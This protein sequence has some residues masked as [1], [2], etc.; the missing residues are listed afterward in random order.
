MYN[1]KVKTEIEIAA[2]LFLEKNPFI[3]KARSGKL[4]KAQITRYLKTILYSIEF[5]PIHLKAASLRANELGLVE[6]AKFMDEK[7]LEEFGHDRWVRA[8]LRKLGANANSNTDIELTQGII[9][10]IKFVETLVYG[11]PLYYI[12]YITFL[13]Y[14]TVLVAPE[15]LDCI[16]NKCGISRTALTVITN[17]GE[18][19]KNHVEDDFKALEIFVDGPEKSSQFIQ[20]IHKTAQILDQHFSECA[21]AA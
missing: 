3:I 2:K 16:V 20:I 4:S 9:D 12:A 18:L 15:L 7:Y 8:D 13:E 10:L 11:N 5:T 19:D 1:K 21:E 14:F 6:I 17:H